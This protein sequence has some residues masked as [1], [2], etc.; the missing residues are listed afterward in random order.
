M[1]RFV[2]A[3]IWIL[4]LAIAGSAMATDP[5]APDTVAMVFSV[6][7]DLTTGEMNAQLD[8]WVFCDSNLVK[9]ATMA[10]DWS[11]PNMQM[12]SAK[13]YPIVTN[14]FGIGP[15]F[16]EDNN[17]AVT[18]AHKR[19]LF[20]GAV[21]FGQGIPGNPTR[22]LWAS[23]YFTLSAWNEC[24]SI[25][26]D[27][28]SWSTSTIWKFVGSTGGPTFDYFPYWGGPLVHV[29]TACQPPINLVVLPDSLYF[30]A[31]QGGSN[32]PGQNFQITT[33]GA[34]VSFN[35]IDNIPWAIV[36]PITGTTP[37][38]GLVTVNIGSLVAGTY[39][40]S[41]AVTSA[42]AANSPQYLKIVLTIT[43][44]PPSIGVVPTQF[45]F[46]AIA[47]G[48]NPDPKILSI[49]N[50]GGQTLNWSVSNNHAWLTLNPL[51]GTDDGDVTL[52][53]DIAGLAYGTYHDTI[54]VAA[55]GANNSPVL[56]PVNLSVA[57][58]LPIIQ[59]TPQFNPV[60]VQTP[61]TTIPPVTVSLTNVGAGTY[62]FSF[63]W[64][65]PRIV[66]ATPATGSSPQ[67]VVFA[68]T[69]AGAQNGQSFYDTVWVHSN[70]ALN[71]PYPI[72]FWFHFVNNPANLMVVQD[73]VRFT[74]YECNLAYG[75]G[76]P[77]RNILA[78]NIG[79]DNPVPVHLE[80]D[81]TD[82]YSTSS[83]QGVLPYEFT[84]QTHFLDLPAG[85]YLDTIWIVAPKAL[86]SPHR[87]IVKYSV[88]EHQEQPLIYL[89][90]TQVATV[91]QE[92]SGPSPQASFTIY[93]YYGGCMDFDIQEDIPWAFLDDQDGTAPATIEF[94]INSSGFPLG[95]YVDTFWVYSDVASNSPQPVQVTMYVFRYYGDVDWSGEINIADLVYL[96][97]YMFEHGPGPMPDRQVGSCDC[98]PVIT[99]ADL[100]WLVDWMFNN[101]P[102]PCGNP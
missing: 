12:D 66:S 7:P 63:Q 15:F 35:V 85:D 55:P 29:D 38:T 48:A 42:Q 101:G 20:G 83:P 61:A 40:D 79:G 34:P 10:W 32:P 27:T 70:E 97:V 23:Y 102:K 87:L 39:V 50:E 19:F 25:V 99:I 14:N 65:S 21:M 60:I 96:V 51:S 93:N 84:I 67:D 62:S 92:N 5:G 36:N 41:A 37:Q 59:V 89:P 1:R 90:N 86:N 45:Y 78:Y 17:I 76:P 98:N 91:T 58:N 2:F 100:L 18:N 75:S 6:A 73:T 31:Q 68:L 77:S 71:S 69:P 11:N 80:Y 88:L 16:Y 46:N 13:G 47:G 72:V 30:Q 54:T 74:L 33:S 49:S 94:R 53:V 82:L 95:T 43:E 4:A 3:G 24:D 22:Q 64:T 44:P 57:S 8:L 81:S 9:G 52:S 26:I 56:V 28:T